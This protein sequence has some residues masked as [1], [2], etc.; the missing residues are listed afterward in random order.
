MYLLI[1]VFDAVL[2]FFVFKL[3]SLV[4]KL[5]SLVTLKQNWT[6]S[7]VIVNIILNDILVLLL[8]MSTNLNY[9]SRT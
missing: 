3:E 9:I 7:T 1:T 6:H 4:T 2:I 8:C 5:E